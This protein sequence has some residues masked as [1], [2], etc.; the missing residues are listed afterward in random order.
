M[1]VHR[2]MC[3]A[4]AQAKAGVT[5]LGRALA[6]SRPAQ[7]PG[8]HSE[9]CAFPCTAA[10]GRRP[11][12]WHGIGHPVFLMPCRATISAPAC[13]R[14]AMKGDG[15]SPCMLALCHE[16]GACVAPWAPLLPLER[17]WS[18]CSS[19]YAD[20]RGE[21]THGAEMASR[22]LA[23]DHAPDHSH[24]TSPRGLHGPGSWWPKH[25]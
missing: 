8:A 11:G 17:V 4:P 15:L 23:A 1:H 3:T 14:S 7:I 10:P 5:D 21:C 18:L 20:L 2:H 9:G 22:H 16:G 12:R 19:A 24:I 6:I 25:T 13:L